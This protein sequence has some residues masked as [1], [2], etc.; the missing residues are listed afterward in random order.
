M[1]AKRVSRALQVLLAPSKR[2]R[3]EEIERERER[4][5]ERVCVRVCVH[6]CVGV[7]VCVCVGVSVYVCMCVC[8]CVCVCVR[9]RER[10]R[11]RKREGGSALQA[12]PSPAGVELGPP[13]ICMRCT[14]VP[15]FMLGIRFMA[16]RVFIRNALTDGEQSFTAELDSSAPEREA[17][18]HA[19]MHNMPPPPSREGTFSRHSSLRE[20]KRRREGGRE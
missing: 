18:P 10:E 14:C 12:P 16:S 19:S 17:S 3:D 6:V 4:K 11:E 9:E 7:C 5:R 1:F 8:V 2:E 15:D 20:R 13:Y